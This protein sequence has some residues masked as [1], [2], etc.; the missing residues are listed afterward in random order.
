MTVKK[1]FVII[2]VFA[3]ADNHKEVKFSSIRAARIYRKQ[4]ISKRRRGDQTA[5]VQIRVA[6]RKQIQ[7]VSR[8]LNL[9]SL[10]GGNHQARAIHV[11][12][13]PYINRFTKK[14]IA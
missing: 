11:P 4:K 1:L 5:T 2:Q 3:N 6:V 12:K 7:R 10:R 8:L 13:L 14:V 9:A